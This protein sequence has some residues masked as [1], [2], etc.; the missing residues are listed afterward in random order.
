M[1]AWAHRHVVSDDS[2][3]YRKQPFDPCE[4]DA[5]YANLEDFVVAAG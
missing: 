5:C 2:T 3:Y 1:L 4:M